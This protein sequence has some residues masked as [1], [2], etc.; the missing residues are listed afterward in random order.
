MTK[1]PEKD[2]E[3]NIR[4][5]TLKEEYLPQIASIFR[6]AFSNKRCC[7]CFPITE[8]SGEMKKR[9]SKYPREKWELGVVALQGDTVFGFCQLTHKDLPLYPGGT[10]IVKPGEMYIETIAVI[11]GAQGRGIGTKL[12]QWSE[13]KARNTERMSTL[14]LEVFKGN[15]AI[16]LYKRFG[17]E[18]VTRDDKDCFAECCE[19]LVVC[20]IFGRP[21]GWCATYVMVKNLH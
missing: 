11:P 20:C 9:Y 14:E 17:F 5:E 18:I 3:T 4:L 19:A 1:A 16:S 21:Y 6:E 13:D 15:Q 12:L 7:G 8:S 10:H 2:E